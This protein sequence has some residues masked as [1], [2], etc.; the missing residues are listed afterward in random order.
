VRPNAK[1]H[2]LLYTVAAEDAAPPQS[3]TSGS[4]HRYLK[5]DDNDRELATVV[6]QLLREDAAR[7]R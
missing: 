2:I 6:A 4:Y 3:P 7:S 5:Q 1:T